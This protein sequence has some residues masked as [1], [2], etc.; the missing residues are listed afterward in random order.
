MPDAESCRR[1]L[2]PLMRNLNIAVATLSPTTTHP[3]TKWPASQR[4]LS[5]P[6]DGLTRTQDLWFQDCGLIIQAEDTIFHVSGTEYD[7]EALRKRTLVHL[8]HA[9]PT[10][11]EAWDALPTLPWSSGL[12]LDTVSIA[13]QLGAEWILPTSFYRIC[14]S[15]FDHEI[16][17]GT[18]LSDTD[19]VTCIKGLRYLENTGAAHVLDFLLA[20]YGKCAISTQCMEVRHGRTCAARWRLRGGSTMPNVIQR[21]RS[22]C[23]SRTPPKC[24][25][26]AFLK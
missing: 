8:S 6:E 15:S 3:K 24:A 11:L 25:P 1:A 4:R 10:T 12:S 23:S 21:C 26:A 2:A 20:S 9:H 22:S 19:K 16:V 18:E 14:Q 7:A 13:R 17:T 5:K